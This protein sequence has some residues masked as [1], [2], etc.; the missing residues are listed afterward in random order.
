[1]ELA[2]FPSQNPSFRTYLSGE[3][4]KGAINI[5]PKKGLGGERKI[6]QTY[7]FSKGDRKDAKCNRQKVGRGMKG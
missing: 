6:S 4:K 5:P 3:A 1:M 2:R 7:A